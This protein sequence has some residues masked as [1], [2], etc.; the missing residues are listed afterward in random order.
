MI[1]FEDI[2]CPVCDG[3]VKVVM[4][5]NVITSH[6]VCDKCERHYSAEHLNFAETCKGYVEEY[7]EMEG[8]Y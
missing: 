6:G 3:K 1:I 7:I 8:G 4:E 2:D 5:N